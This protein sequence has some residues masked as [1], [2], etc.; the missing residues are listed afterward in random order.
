MRFVIFI[1]AIFFATASYAQEFKPF[2]EARITEAQWVTYFDDVKKSY[3]VSKR[4][5]P[6]EHLVVFNDLKT[7][8]N[9]AFTTPGHAAHPAWITRQPVADEFGKTRVN[10]IG[11]FAG[12]EQPFARLFN[13]YL[14]LTESTIK[15]IPSD[16]GKQQTTQEIS[17]E[18]A[19]KLF[20]QSR[21]KLGYKEY[22]TEFAQFSNR[23][24]LPERGGCSLLGSGEVKIIVIISEKGVI[25]SVVTE[26]DSEKAKC[27]KRN[28]IGIDVKKPPYSP[29]AFPII[30]Q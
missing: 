11:Y 18:E 12:Q 22:V 30:Y 1:T 2:P 9:W 16:A 13:D 5:F 24:R 7:G 28:Y 15:K 3:E 27:Y 29:F 26:S 10:Q 8:M 14:A 6:D 17:F 25:D 20:Q 23:I 4:E 21:Q 19:F